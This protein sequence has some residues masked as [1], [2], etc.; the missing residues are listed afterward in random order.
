MWL[1]CALKVN[2][3]ICEDPFMK[4]RR[5]KTAGIRFWGKECCSHQ[6]RPW[7]S[8]LGLNFIYHIPQANIL[9]PVVLQAPFSG[10]LKMNF[11]KQYIRG[12]Q[13]KSLRVSRKC[14]FELLQLPK[15]RSSSP[16]AA[17]TPHRKRITGHI[18]G[19]D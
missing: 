15:R 12:L 3:R 14:R 2:Q 19:S 1:R 10:W 16:G 4:K 9:S 13:S 7:V 6:A 8:N 11:I 18:C 17:K 5:W